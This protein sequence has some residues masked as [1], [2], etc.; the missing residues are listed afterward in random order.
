MYV[1]PQHRPFDI[2]P[3]YLLLLEVASDERW[4]PEDPLLVQLQTPFDLA[5]VKGAR[6]EIAMELAARCISLFMRRIIIQKQHGM[7]VY[8]LSLVVIYVCRSIWSHEQR[9]TG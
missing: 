4:E 9:A 2:L 8:I 1:P 3:L 7:E 5:Y 6:E